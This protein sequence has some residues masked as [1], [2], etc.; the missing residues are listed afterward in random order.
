MYTKSIDEV[1]FFF[2]NYPDKMAPKKKRGFYKEL[3]IGEDVRMAVNLKLQ[4]FRNNEDEKGKR[5]SLILLCMLRSI[6]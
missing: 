1:T 4:D 3:T 5:V 2:V 6:L